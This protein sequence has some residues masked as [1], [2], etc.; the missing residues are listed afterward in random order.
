MNNF[1][2][3]SIGNVLS[4]VGVMVTLVAF[5]RSNVSRIEAAAKRQQ[6]M[7]LKIELLYEWF[8]ENVVGRGEPPRHRHG[9]GE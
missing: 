8:K 9:G 4:F 7:E 1:W 2:Q 5:H 3:V 6:A